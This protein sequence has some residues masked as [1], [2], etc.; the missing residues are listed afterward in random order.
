MQAIPNPSASSGS[1]KED[2]MPDSPGFPQ[3]PFPGLPFPGVQGFPVIYPQS[4]DG[5]EDD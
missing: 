4:P 1:P 3:G 5:N 2:D